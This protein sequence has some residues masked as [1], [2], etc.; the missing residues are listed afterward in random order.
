MKPIITEVKK[1]AML[2]FLPSRLNFSHF[3]K[4]EV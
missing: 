1:K 3:I 2:K 4:K